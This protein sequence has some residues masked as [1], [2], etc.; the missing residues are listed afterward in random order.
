[1]TL[2]VNYTQNLGA[3]IAGMVANVP[4]QTVSG[5]SLDSRKVESGW[6]F[7]S[8]AQNDQQR[9][10]YL[11]QALDLGATVILFDVGVGLTLVESKLI[12]SAQA[13][14]YPILQLAQN[15]SEIAARYYDFPS[16]KMTV[17]A[18]TGTNGK[19]SVSQFIA[20]S[21]DYLGVECGVIGTLG[22]G[23]IGNLSSTGMTTP[24]PVL[25]QAVFAELYSQGCSHVVIEA[26]SHALAQGR[27]NSVAIDIAIL[28]NLS[29]D[30]LD[31]HNTMEEYALAKKQLFMFEGLSTAILN[32]AD[33]F[34]QS[35]IQDLV[36]NQ[37]VRVI[38]YNAHTLDN[39]TLSA[40][41]IESHLSGM[42]FTI[43][44]QEQTAQIK[45][46]LLGRFNVDNLLATLAGLVAIDVGFDQACQAIQQ[47]HAVE[48]RMQTYSAQN[49]AEVVIDFAH[50]P[51]ALTQ[52][53]TSLRTHLPQQGLLWCVFGCG[54]DRDK[55]KR[56]VMGQ[57]AEL[58]ADKIVLTADNPRSEN[59]HEI[60]ADILMGITKP[61]TIHIEHDR[62][63]AITFAITHASQQD[64]VLVAGK[65]HENYQEIAGNKI[66]FSDANAVVKALQAAN[67]DNHSIAEVQ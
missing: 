31:Y 8:L 64:I 11:K 26:S 21:L 2:P 7:L 58:Y 18:I 43:S 36:A 35:L 42:S 53:L 60:V 13:E 4:E 62:Q 46:S 44:Y 65:G 29:R 37:T 48:G 40:T 12:E 6:L 47:C 17:I 25:M 22:V 39:S 55:G 38:S 59:N 32:T 57:C 20:Q 28:T 56:A 61:E 3:L 10:A 52:A 54:G 34:G 33:V 63:Q 1:M 51:D 27:L 23:K 45:S 41:A 5:L 16:D 9:T 30:H 14:A 49:Q 19:T 15:A 50:T 66:P 24:D 67:D